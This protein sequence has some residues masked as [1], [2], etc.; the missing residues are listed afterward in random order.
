MKNSSYDVFPVSFYPLGSR[1]LSGGK[2]KKKND[3]TKF[4]KDYF[5]FF[6]KKSLFSSR[7]SLFHVHFI[8]NSGIS[9]WPFQLPS[10]IN[11]S[12]KQDKN[13]P[14]TSKNWSIIANF[15]PRKAGTGF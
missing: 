15:H 13:T 3:S 6:L 1:L 10:Y 14:K 5:L 12:K 11:K 9:F 2:S 8:Q 7:N 4:F